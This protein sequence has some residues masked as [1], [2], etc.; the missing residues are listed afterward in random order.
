[1]KFIKTLIFALIFFSSSV[2]AQGVADNLITLRINHS[3]DEAMIAVKSTLN[4]YGY[5]IAHIQKCDGGLTDMGYKTKNY[6]LIF[7]GKL[8]EIRT[9]SKTYP[10]IIPFVPLKL[11]VIQEEGSVIL[12]ALNPM[13]LSDF[14]SEKKLHTQ[15]K[16]WEKDLKALFK[17]MKT[18]T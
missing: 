16:L 17:E 1:M 2:Q 5:K 3:F 18:N 4:D 6:K 12:V 9:L 14:F 11:A 7:F 8:D 15:F 10:A 13:S